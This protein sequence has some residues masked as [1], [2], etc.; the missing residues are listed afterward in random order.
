MED[1]NK[2]ILKIRKEWKYKRE[3][4][5][6]V[7][8]IHDKI[9]FNINYYLTRVVKYF[10]FDSALVLDADDPI[11]ALRLRPARLAVVSN[12]KLVSTQPRADAIMNLSGRPTKKNRRH[13]IPR[14]G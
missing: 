8:F 7:P 5:D 10:K 1:F 4:K 13:P 11:D 9:K 3:G 14:L 2:K 12:G 6:Y